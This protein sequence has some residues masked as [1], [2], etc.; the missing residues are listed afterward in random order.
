MNFHEYQ[1]KQLFADYGI[2][3]PAGRVASTPE[4]AVEAANALGNGP[5]M[6]KAQIH[7]GGRGKA[8]GVK[9]CKTT[10]DVKAAAAKMLGTSMETYQSAGVAL[11][12]GLVLVTEAGEIA[13]ELY[14]SVLVDRG[15]QSITYIA[16]SEG[17]VDIE[18]VAAETPE[19]IQSLNVNFVEGLQPYQAR[20]IGFKLGLNAKQANQLA[21]IMGG[22]YTLFNE[23]DLALVELNPLAILDSGDLYALDGKVNSDDNAT[24]RHKDLAAMRDK[25]QEDEAEVRASEYDLNYVTMDG[26]IGCMVNGAGL[27]MATMD[28]IALNGGAPANFLDVGGG[29]TKERVTEAFKLILSS[30][31][32]KAIFVNIFGGI[33]RC[34]MIAEGI[35]AAVKEV[36]VKVP[37]VVRLEG[38]NVEA[39]KKLLAD[40]GLAITPADDINDGA[41]KVV[42]AVAA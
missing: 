31:K 11:P 39:G 26:N 8:G 16:S 32:V 17:G 14:L 6:V 12:I 9:F 18:Q 24:F 21:K 3:V 29:A 35:I 19:K 20:E 40:S 2:P 36:D 38:T 22:L 23:K 42:A 37:V 13:K 28:V 1:A 4:E 5:W 33:V 7:A 30:D 41:K 15:T 34:D 10:D 25:T 27:A